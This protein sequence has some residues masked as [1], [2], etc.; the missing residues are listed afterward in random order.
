MWSLPV[1]FTLA[2]TAKPTH[3]PALREGV[4]VLFSRPKEIEE[5][6]A[7]VFTGFADAQADKVVADAFFRSESLDDP[8]ERGKGFDGVLGVVVVPWH[9]VEDQKGKE[10][11]AILS[12]RSLTFIAVSLCR[13]TS[14]ICR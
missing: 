9:S 3:A 12:N 7:Q 5:V 11:V 8:P 6:Q 13:G 14:E 1:H 2:R 4:N 10:L